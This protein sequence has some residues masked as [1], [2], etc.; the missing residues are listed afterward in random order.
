M[1]S[2]GIVEASTCFG[3]SELTG[4]EALQALKILKRQLAP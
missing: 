4:V 3:D 2:I 1:N